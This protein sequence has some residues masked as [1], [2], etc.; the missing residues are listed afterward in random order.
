MPERFERLIAALEGSWPARQLEA[1]KAWLAPVPYEPP[2]R[3]ALFDLLIALL[4]AALGAF[5]SAVNFPTIDAEINRHFDVY[6]QSDPVRVLTGM[7]DRSSR[8]FLRTEVHPIFPILTYPLTRLL[9][10]FGMTP[11]GAA[12][13]LVTACAGLSTG[14]LFLAVRGLGM[15]RIV[16]ALF[17]AV[18]VSSAAFLFWFS[19]LETYAFGALTICIMMVL[20]VYADPRRTAAWTLASAATLAIT[21]TNWGFGLAASFFRLKL[22]SF[23]MVSAAALA[24]VAAL[25]IVQFKAFPVAPLFFTPGAYVYETHFLVGAKQMKVGPPWVPQDNLRAVLI[26]SAVAP[27]T[28][29]AKFYDFDGV[30]NQH[31]GLA[32]STPG[33]W[34]AMASWLFLLGAGIWGVVRER[35]RRPVGLAL[36]AYALFQLS[37][38]FVYGEI[39]FLYVLNFFPA[40]VALAAFSWFTPVRGLAIAAAAVFVLFAPDVNLRQFKATAQLA[41]QVTRERGHEDFTRIPAV[42]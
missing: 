3:I 38:H 23:V 15:P 22:R 6:F 5:V 4:L 20:L 2:G 24:L 31:T 11:M 17:S 30:T 19:F 27:T 40:L 10:L 12:D 28:V 13:L 37:L 29:K 35:A 7:A 1:I 34:A 14:L 9:M 42:R 16:A 33:A 26:S 32:G 18:F 41:N 8:L 36:A 39:T 21:T 25:A